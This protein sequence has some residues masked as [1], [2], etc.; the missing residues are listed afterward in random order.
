MS[1]RA[2]SLAHRISLLSA[3]HLSKGPPGRAAESS[4]ASLLKNNLKTRET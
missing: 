2:S 4:S 3:L 1:V